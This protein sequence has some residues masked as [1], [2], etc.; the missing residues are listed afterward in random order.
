MKNW[1]I[2]ILL[3][4][5]YLGTFHLWI[6]L[7]STSIVITGITITLILSIAIAVAK[8]QDYFVNNFDLFGHAT[9]PL[10]ITLE[11]IL[12]PDHNHYGFY[13]CALGFTIVIGGYRAYSLKSKLSSSEEYVSKV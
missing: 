8:K 10:D 11:A 7:S 2:S 6:H 9:L 5:T 3:L 13:F 4:L 12:I 1:Y